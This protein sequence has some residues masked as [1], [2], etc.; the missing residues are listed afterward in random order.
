ML[1]WALAFGAGY[2]AHRLG[3]KGGRTALHLPVSYYVV[4]AFGAIFGAFALG[5]ANLFLSGH[6]G[7]IGRSIVGALSGGIVAVEIY[8]KTTGLK[9]STGVS[10]VAAFAVGTAI[11]RIGCYV[12]GIEDFTYGV[13]TNL[14]WGVDFG[15][16]VHRHPVQIYESLVMAGF[17]VT[18]FISL[19]RSA[20]WATHQAFYYMV[21]VYGTERFTFE[22][23]KPYAK[24]VGPFNLFHLVC[25][26]LVIYALYMLRGKN[27][28]N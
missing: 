20:Y 27:G 26:A 22:F 12:S 17:A 15:G 6:E 7:Q 9:G 28:N 8:K 4:L 11:G 21:L 19:K 25:A 5:T 16:G 13:E 23:F 3:R 24:L 18:Y 2:W 1:A 10:F 14:P